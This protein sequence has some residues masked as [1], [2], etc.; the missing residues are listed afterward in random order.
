[1]TDHLTD[2]RGN[3][4]VR[5]GNEVENNDVRF[6]VGAVN[7]SQRLC[8]L[9]KSKPWTLKNAESPMAE[10]IRQGSYSASTENLWIVEEDAQ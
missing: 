2:H 4:I 5:I 10:C 6:F 3:V 7:E 1:M 9:D 8:T